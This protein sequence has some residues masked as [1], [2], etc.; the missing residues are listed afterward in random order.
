MLAVFEDHMDV[1]GNGMG[2]CSREVSLLTILS[3]HGLWCAAGLQCRSLFYLPLLTC[4]FGVL[5]SRS[6][7][8]DAQIN[9]P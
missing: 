7:A 3:P 9:L 5:Q 6:V 2:P 8:E 4:F 1:N